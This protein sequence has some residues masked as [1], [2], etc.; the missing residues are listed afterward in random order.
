[1]QGLAKAR[2]W[3]K[4]LAAFGTALF[5]GGIAWIGLLN[6]RSRGY[7]E[8]IRYEIRLPWTPRLMVFLGLVLLVIVATE[9]SINFLH[10]R[11]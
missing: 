5:I 7:P 3:T 6:Y 11:D 10:N 1:M 2:K 4:R 8:A 9:I